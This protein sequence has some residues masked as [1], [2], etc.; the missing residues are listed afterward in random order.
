VPASVTFVS[1]STGWVLGYAPC[2]YT[3]CLALLKTV[4][5]GRTWASVPPPPTLFEGAEIND[6]AS[7]T[8]IRFADTSD[9]WAYAPG[10]WAT[11]D[12][13]DH[14]HQISL[15]SRSSPG[16]INDVEA[17]RGMVSAA[18]RD[19]DGFTRV[20]TSATT[21]DSWHESPLVMMG[22]AGPVPQ[23]TIV[24]SQGGGWIVQV[25][26]TVLDGAR[27]VRTG[28]SAWRPP[29]ETGGGGL[30]LAAATAT[31]LAAVC[32]DGQWANFPT[33]VVVSFSSNAGATFSTARRQPAMEIAGGAASPRPGDVVIWTV[34][35]RGNV[36]LVATFNGGASW[37]NVFGTTT[38][39]G[40][41]DL[42][43]TS[44]SQGVAVLSNDAGTSGEVL[45]TFDAGHRWAPMPFRQA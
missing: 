35:A 12:G 34:D 20:E 8:K 5:A 27:L 32:T 31:S 15:P 39:Q 33:R 16:I 41:T 11:H 25:D 45:M 40:V 13:G 7:V 14:W 38:E 24:L 29:C 42:G 18:L 17:A 30:Y 2:E 44:A 28:W 4:N 3:T 36:A 19:Y 6:P 23:A 37:V 22:G 26:R 9:G 43:F 21:I 1:L 10:L